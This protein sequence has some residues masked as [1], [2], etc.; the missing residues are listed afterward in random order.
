M[1]MLD[2]RKKSNSPIRKAR[3]QVEELC[4]KPAGGKLIMTRPSS[5]RVKQEFKVL[6]PMV[7][8]RGNDRPQ[9]M[10]K[11]RQPITLID[12]LYDENNL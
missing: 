11:K 5:H 4:Y 2:K 6:R 8:S 10:G 7:A 1:K 12:L 3:T 9:S